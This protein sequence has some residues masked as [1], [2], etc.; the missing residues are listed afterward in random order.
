MKF[1]FCITN[2]A[3]KTSYNYQNYLLESGFSGTDS[4]VLEM[5]HFLE[6]AGHYCKIVFDY[7]L[8]SVFDE[9][10]DVFCPEF[11]LNSQAIC[12]FLLSLP[13][14]TKILLYLQ[15]FITIEEEMLDLLKTRNTKIVGV[16]EFVEKYYKSFVFP[17]KTIYNAINPT[18]FT[19]N[20]IDYDNK[21]GNF[22]FFASFER[23]GI[24]ALSIFKKLK[25]PNKKMY[26]CSYDINDFELIQNISKDKDIIHT[27]APNTTWTSRSVHVY[28]TAS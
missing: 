1:L 14:T 21:K 7:E 8:L 23:G 19:N 27:K 17:Y 28:A 4:Q 11:F 16:S 2:S 20:E 6:K 12:I 26:I 9:H 15:S 13:K 24:M 5:C 18:I 25:I 10:W 22:V 3:R